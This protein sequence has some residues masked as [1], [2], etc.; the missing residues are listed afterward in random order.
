MTPK[1]F[2]FLV[3]ATAI[4]LAASIGAVVVESRTAAGPVEV[5]QPLFPKLVARANEVAV[6]RFRNG[7][8]ESTI[9]RVGDGWGF[10]E[11]AGYPVP[12]D[13]VR[14]VVAGIASLR[15]FEQKTD[16]PELYPRLGVQDIGAEN[17]SSREVILETADG[18]ELAAIILGRVSNTM[19][20]DPLGGMYVREPGNPRTWLVR[21]TVALPR[22]AAEW[23]VQQVI[24]IPGPDIQR[25]VIREGGET[26][27]AAKQEDDDLIRYHMEPEVEGIRAV[28][29]AWKQVAS[30]AVSVIFENVVPIGEI[31]GVEFTRQV[32]YTT[33]DGMTVKITTFAIDEVVWVTFSASAEPGSE[34]VERAETINAVAAD[35]AY[36]LPGY[37]LRAIHRDV[38]DLTEVIPEEAPAGVPGFPGAIQLAPGVQLPAGGL[39]LP[40]GIN[41]P[42]LTPAPAV[43][44]PTPPPA[45]GGGG[46]GG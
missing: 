2:V 6:L 1:S 15:R 17:S 38:A 9:V 33:S 46:G 10:V 35:W 26:L 31:A 16:Q 24:H 44:A 36:Q 4:G 13:N 29:S 25:V 27:I 3:G 34:G 32:E 39:P 23:M 12:T 21:G 8:T 7:D 20:F 28:D 40:P 37:K 41:I 18:E 22:T 19:Q 5:D 30:G 43:P 42:G 45:G 11:R 14:T